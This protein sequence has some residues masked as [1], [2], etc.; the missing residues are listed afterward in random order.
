MGDQELAKD[1]TEA[2]SVMNEDHAGT[3]KSDNFLSQHDSLA[4]TNLTDLADEGESRLS[5]AMAVS[6]SAPTLST[7]S[8]LRSK[9]A[10]APHM[11]SPLRVP[12]PPNVATNVDKWGFPN[13]R[14]KIAA[15]AGSWDERHQLLGM[16]NDLCPQ[17]TRVYFQRPQ[18]MVQLKMELASNTRLQPKGELLAQI[19]RGDLPLPRSIISC[20]AGVPILPDKHE[21]GGT[22]MD[23]DGMNRTWNTRWQTGIAMMNEHCH[24]DHRAYF[25]QRSVFERSPS[26]NYRRFLHQEINGN[27]VHVDQKRQPI[28]PPLGGLLRGRS[29]APIPGA[30]P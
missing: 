17:G 3:A 15:H 20:D 25:T 28:F 27:W 18:T 1:S 23:R 30:T 6:S 5:P 9:K 12:P 21:P 26:Q 8:K 13:A 24:M 4:T 10:K 22:M 16:P 2:L 19:E 29:G 14:P 11:R 7:Q